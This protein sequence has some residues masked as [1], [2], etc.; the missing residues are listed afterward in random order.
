MW[1]S[2]KKYSLWHVCGLVNA[3]IWG[4]GQEQG[5]MLVLAQSFITA[6]SHTR[7]NHILFPQVYKYQIPEGTSANNA[8]NR[9]EKTQKL[10]LH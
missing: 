3:V 7:A 10:K 4:Q 8:K 5:S 2:E 6:Y 9:K 1:A